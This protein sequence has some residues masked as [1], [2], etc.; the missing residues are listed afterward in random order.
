MTS[1]LRALARLPRPKVCLPLV[2]G[3]IAGLTPTVHAG[4]LTVA[5]DPN[6]EPDLAGYVVRYRSEDDVHRGSTNVGLVTQATVQNLESGK[7]YFLSVVAYNSVGLSSP[8]SSEVT[9]VVSGAPPSPTHRTNNYFAEGAGGIFDYRL[10]LLNTTASHATVNVSFLIEGAAPVTRTYAVRGQSRTSVYA[11]EVPE[12]GLSAFGAV[13]AAPAGVVSERTMSWKAGGAGGAHTAK[14]LQAPATQWF[15][16]EG[17]AGFFE[18][19]VLLA[20]PNPSSVTANVSFLTDTGK[21]V[22]RSYDLAANQ[23]KTIF[24]NELPELTF[25]SFA[26][27]VQA[28]APIL[29]ERAM[30]FRNG[31][32]IWQGGHASAAVTTGA[33]SWFLAEGQT[34]H[35]FDTFVLIGNPNSRPVTAT[36]NYLTPAGLALTETRTLEPTSRM[37]ILLDALPKLENTEV[38]VAITASAPIIVERSMYWPGEPG[39]W[40]SAHN[41]VGLTELATKWALAEGEVGG[42]NSAATFVLLANPGGAIAKVTLTVYRAPGLGVKQFSRTVGPGARLTVSSDEMG[43]ASGEQ[44]GVVVESTQPIAVERSIYWSL[45]GQLWTSGTNETGTKIP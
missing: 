34:G 10:A 3:L 35:W 15:L 45:D 29:V 8:P 7:R 1:V 44:F 26:T 22:E 2:I 18:T 43:L 12:I 9:A 4:S 27:T 6:T 23:R 19:F 40:H 39:P 21:V 32:S 14:S 41:S 16:A 30:Y 11:S 36:I 33:T 17:N 24:T 37:T 31:A 42:P 25:R 13:V 38:S 28:A 5:W 20:N